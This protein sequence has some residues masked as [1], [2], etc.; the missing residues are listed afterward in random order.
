MTYK[1]KSAVLK[2]EHKRV[3]GIDRARMM[4]RLAEVQKRDPA[5]K[6][7]EVSACR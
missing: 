7:I 3:E 4:R 2:A 6:L 5:A 1:I